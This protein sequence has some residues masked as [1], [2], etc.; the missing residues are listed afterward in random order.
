VLLEALNAAVLQVA[1]LQGALDSRLPIEQAKGYVAAR[2]EVSTHAA[3]EAL[4]RYSRNHNL[5]LREVCVDIVAGTLPQ[6]DVIIELARRE[7]QLRH[8]R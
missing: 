4:R 5:K 8:T 6:A 1:R 7:E 3:F 2:A